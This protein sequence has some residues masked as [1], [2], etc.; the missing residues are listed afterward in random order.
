MEDRLLEMADQ[1]LRIWEIYLNGIGDAGDELNRSLKGR[2]TGRH[3][4]TLRK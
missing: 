2:K 3:R 4:K 1:N